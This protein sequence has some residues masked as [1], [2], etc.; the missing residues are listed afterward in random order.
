MLIEDRK[1][2]MPREDAL[3]IPDSCLHVIK[4]KQKPEG[5]VTMAGFTVK[6]SLLEL[7]ATFTLFVAQTLLSNRNLSQSCPLLQAGR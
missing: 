6:T 2:G 5:N 1:E 7:L 4:K 3:Q